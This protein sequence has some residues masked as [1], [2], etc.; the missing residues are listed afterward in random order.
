M[1]RRVSSTN[2]ELVPPATV[3]LYFWAI[4]R[5]IACSAAVSIC[6]A[7]LVSLVQLIGGWNIV[8][9]GLFQVF[10]YLSMAT[11]GF[12]AAKTT[13]RKGWL[14]GGLVGILFILGLNWMTTGSLYVAHVN[15]KDVLRLGVGFIMGAVGGVLGV[16]L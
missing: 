9:A 2:N 5:G 16:N 15:Q 1:A 7:V 4:V 3:G 10:S 12:L 11:G 13:Q 6:G 14:V 8:E